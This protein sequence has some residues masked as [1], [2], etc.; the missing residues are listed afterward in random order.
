MQAAKTFHVGN[1]IQREANTEKTTKEMEEDLRT[2][3][4]SKQPDPTLPSAQ[5]GFNFLVLTTCI[6]YCSC[7]CGHLTKT[8]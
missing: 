1:T 7:C 5:T 3:T 8:T 4:S 6:T 2:Q